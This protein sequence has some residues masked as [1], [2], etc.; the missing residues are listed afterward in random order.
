MANPAVTNPG[1]A[2]G[3]SAIATPTS[4]P[5]G[6]GAGADPGGAQAGVGVQPMSIQPLP[7]LQDGDGVREELSLALPF[8]PVALAFKD[9][10]YWVKHP[11]GSGE[12]ELLKASDVSPSLYTLHIL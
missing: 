1:P 2:Y 5:D 9:V 10:H 3:G 7:D 11:R 6:R 4:P 8:E 12:L